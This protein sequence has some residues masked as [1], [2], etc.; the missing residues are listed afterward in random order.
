MEIEKTINTFE[1]IKH[2]NEYGVEY[3]YARELMQTLEYSKWSNF[4]K[5]IDKAKNACKLSNNK[6]EDHF[7]DVGKTIKCL[8]ELQ[9]QLMIINYQGMLAI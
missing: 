1:D 2:I 4:E 7:A 9:K 5:V 6:V 8:K 3:W